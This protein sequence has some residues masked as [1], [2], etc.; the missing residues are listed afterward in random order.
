MK[1]VKVLKSLRCVGD[2]ILGCLLFYILIQI[3]NVRKYSHYIFI[4]HPV[5]ELNDT[6]NVYVDISFYLSNISHI[7]SNANYIF[8]TS[9]GPGRMDVLPPH[10][11]N[12]NDILKASG[13]HYNKLCEESIKSGLLADSISN[14]YYAADIEASDNFAAVIPSSDIRSDKNGIFLHNISQMGTNETQKN[15]D[16]IMEKILD[17]S[18]KREIEYNLSPLFQYNSNST[19]IKSDYALTYRG[20]TFEIKHHNEQTSN[21]FFAWI[22]KVFEPNDITKE[23]HTF[24]VHSESIDTISLSLVFDESIELSTLVKPFSIKSLNEIEFKDITTRGEVKYKVDNKY[25]YNN[26]T[27]K[28]V[29]LGDNYYHQKA[30]DNKISFWV[31]YM[32]SEKIQWLRLFVLTTFLGLIL[33]DFIVCSYKFI[34]NITKSILSK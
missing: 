10:Y 23:E 21:D 24:V 3:L 32:Q 12:L 13:V 14:L 7:N 30:V 20:R 2:I 31:K 27:S 16:Y 34:E 8:H 15:L 9:T 33:T 29:T 11:N 28:S 25:L 6:N 19:I 4:L 5:A 22:A 26:F 18:K 17:V 1:I